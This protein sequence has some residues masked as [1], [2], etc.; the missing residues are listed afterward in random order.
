MFVNNSRMKRIGK[1]MDFGNAFRPRFSA[2][3]AGERKFELFAD[4]TAALA[5][6][7]ATWNS[8][9][10]DFREARE[11]RGRARLALREALAA[12]ARTAKAA[13]LD[14]PGIDL[15]LS[16]GPARGDARLL[17]SARGVLKQLPAA[18][19]TLSTLGLPVDFPAAVA[20]Q[21][22]NLD[23]AMTDQTG[24]RAAMAVLSGRIRAETEKAER[25]A[26]S[27]DAIIRNTL[28]S[29]HEAIAAWN[30][31]WRMPHQ[32]RKAVPDTVPAPAPEPPPS[33]R[34]DRP[35]MR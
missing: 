28:A 26:L 15:K 6:L 35:A 9:A 4:A 25:A 12:V 30:R 1:V 31:A 17:A 14:Q 10:A 27:L 16:A 8:T 23:R 18:S 29:D 5:D 3:S 19:A 33:R 21:I 34:R 13:A 2:E 24:L 32:R 7:S 11:R 20:A 22:H